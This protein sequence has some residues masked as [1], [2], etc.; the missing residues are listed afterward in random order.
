MVSS[1]A[2]LAVLAGGI[3]GCNGPAV[4]PVALPTGSVGPKDPLA[5]R[6]LVVINENSQ[7]SIEVGQYY[8]QKRQ[9]PS[10]NVFRVKTT[11]L[12]QSTV[13]EFNDDVAPSLRQKLSAMAGK[14]DFILLTKGFPLK[15]RD[16]RGV[17]AY[18]S[19]ME[20]PTE[21]KN[22]LR[23][24][25]IQQIISPYLGKDEKFSRSKY[26]FY[27]VTRL[28]GYSVSDAKALVDRS[29]SAKPDRGP[30]VFD[31]AT[32][33]RKDGYGK[34]QAQYGPAM[35]SLR[36]RGFSVLT[37]TDKAMLVPKDPVMGY[38]GWGSNDSGFNQDDYQRL[39]FKPGGIAETFVSTGGRTFLPTTGGQS[40]IADLV[41]QGVTGVKGYVSEPFLF[42]MAQPEVLFDRYTKGYTLAES[43]Y[44]ASP[45]LGSRDV[46]IGDP[47]C[48]PYRK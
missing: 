21:A 2:A 39:R 3:V 13:N 31:E 43:F 46:I 17:D 18:I 29:L 28:D 34:L 9:I 12:E 16:G 45:I 26:G 44:M 6:V 8:V 30:F 42:S 10:T 48:R 11:T 41:A 37:D 14:I 27:L 40:L 23:N 20:M 35:E 19:V 22:A 38:M 5:D 4:P 15:F 25:Q 32:N 1:F 33:R 36:E 7:E 47:I 24:V